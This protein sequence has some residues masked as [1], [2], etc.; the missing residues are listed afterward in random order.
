VKTTLH[1][2]K[3][4][5]AIGERIQSLLDEQGMS[6]AALAGA[7]GS[8]KP[9]ISRLLRGQINVGIEKL[10]QIERELKAAIITV[11]K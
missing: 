5:L 1:T 10:A 8:P 11:A 9:Y 3:L 6:Q 2:E 7:I 4:K